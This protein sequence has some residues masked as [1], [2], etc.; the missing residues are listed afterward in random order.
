M[1]IF[2]AEQRTLGSF[3]PKQAM[4]LQGVYHL[5]VGPVGKPLEGPAMPAYFYP[6]TNERLTI[7]G[8]EIWEELDL[9]NQ[10]DDYKF[11][12]Y[13]RD[14]LSKHTDTF[15]IEVR[16]GD[17]QQAKA[18]MPKDYINIASDS[19]NECFDFPY[20]PTG[21]QIDLTKNKR[22]DPYNCIPL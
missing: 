19:L 3:P 17:C 8:T 1:P 11:K 9:D 13:I 15:P 22:M 6:S 18:G 16:K 12:L 2:S 21:K 14:I 4:S 7:L 10:P 5:A 20:Q